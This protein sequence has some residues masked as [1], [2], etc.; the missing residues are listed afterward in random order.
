MPAIASIKN[1]EFLR[2][3]PYGLGCTA[4]NCASS[5]D[6]GPRASV[7]KTH[8]GQAYEASNPTT[9]LKIPFRMKKKTTVQQNVKQLLRRF[10]ER[11]FPLGYW[12]EF[13]EI[14]KLHLPSFLTCFFQIFLQTIS[15]IMCGH[16]SK[17]QLDAAALACTLINVAGMGIGLGLSTGC[18]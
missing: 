2:N 5:S 17:E 9:E 8:L 6:A 13:R 4:S 14:G 16:L 15:V 10:G 1:G 18:D 3:N 12:K 7:M 11:F